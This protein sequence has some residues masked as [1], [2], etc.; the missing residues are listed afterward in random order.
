MGS[1]DKGKGETDATDALRLR[2]TT[3][4]QRLKN[5]AIVG[6]PAFDK[7]SARADAKLKSVPE[8]RRITPSP[9]IEAP[10]ALHYVLLGE[11]EEVAELREMFENLLA[12]S[13]DRETAA[14]AHPAFVSM[15]SQLT[16]DE[17]RILKSIDRDDYALVNLYEV[18]A[19]GTRL[20]G[21]R[22][23]LG[24]GTG[25]DEA[26]QQQYISNLDRLGIFSGGLVEIHFA[27][28]S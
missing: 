25:I 3:M 23:R 14:S 4:A 8:S 13:M 18:G 22:A 10:I 20:L 5:I 27:A 15:I 2:A 7:L 1:D 11:S 17:A 19:D 9:T 26:R 12:S 24:I 16:P 6:Q 21:F 28:G